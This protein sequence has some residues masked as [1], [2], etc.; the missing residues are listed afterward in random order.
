MYCL[1]RLGTVVALTLAL[2]L[3]TFADGHMPTGPGAAPPSGRVS[4]TTEGVMDCPI[5]SPPAPDEFNG[6]VTQTM[7]NLIE[8]VLAL[9]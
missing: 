2:T 5:T 4:S 3:P 7:L 8:G 1:Q 9:L 6:A